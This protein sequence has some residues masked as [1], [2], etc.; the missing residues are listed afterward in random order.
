MFESP[1][2]TAAA[3]WTALALAALLAACRAGYRDVIDFTASEDGSPGAVLAADGTDFGRAEYRSFAIRRIPGSA[4]RVAVDRQDSDFALWHIEDPKHPTHT[5]SGAINY[6]PIPRDTAATPEGLRDMVEKLYRNPP[7]GHRL[8]SL[9][10]EI[11]PDDA[12]LPGIRYRCTVVDERVFET[13]WTVAVS[14]CL[15][16]DP[17]RSGQIL[18]A[19]Y[20][21]RDRK[22]PDVN[23]KNEYAFF[24][25]IDLRTP[26]GWKPLLPVRT[27]APR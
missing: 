23:R 13:P 17:E 9:D 1:K 6:V 3:G 27:A 10:T 26:D 19:V 7:S 5:V 20:V 25:A 16:L 12:P 11:M 8:I 21:E 15:M 2:R 18:T 4:W 14:G 22:T 24:K